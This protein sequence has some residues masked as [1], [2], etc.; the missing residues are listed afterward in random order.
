MIA[1]NKYYRRGDSE[2][3]YHLGDTPLLV[4]AFG[5]V[6]D[7]YQQVTKLVLSSI[8]GEV[9]ISRI[10]DTISYLTLLCQLLE[11]QTSQSYEV[12]ET[13]SGYAIYADQVLIWHFKAES[14]K[15]EEKTVTQLLIATHNEGKTKEFRELFAPMGITVENLNAHPELPEVE[16]TGTTFE[17]NARLKA[18]TIADLTGQMVLADDS[19]LMVDILGG[20][21]G[22]WSARF[23]GNDASDEENMAKLLH[24][25]AMVFEPEARS[26][27]F[28]TTLVVAKPGV[29][30][31]VIEGEWPGYIA[32]EPKGD[33]GFGYDP[34]F[35]VGDSQ[36]TAA[37][38]SP[39]E[40]NSQSHRGQAVKNLM[41]EFP[42]WQAK[43]S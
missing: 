14:V 41:K 20:M 37:Q 1:T 18:E 30:S 23:A 43:H 21:P 12:K 17:E 9:F 16:E 13:S 32:F 39:E 28:H 11:D 35:L 25:L 4:M 27:H 29:D 19:G 40:K 38:L 15:S 31:L 10:E 26:A 6:E 3:I 8:T 5:D 34:I 22:V 42:L 2:L 33:Q 24:E 7:W 36:K